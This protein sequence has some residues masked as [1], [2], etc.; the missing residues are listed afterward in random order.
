M[1]TNFRLAIQDK[2]AFEVEF[3]QMTFCWPEL[4]HVPIRS[5]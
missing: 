4:G 5:C 1:D 2:G 3:G